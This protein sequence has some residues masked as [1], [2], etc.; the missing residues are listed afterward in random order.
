MV[1][2]AGI[3]A[4][5]FTPGGGPQ[6][7]AGARSCTAFHGSPQIQTWIKVN[8]SE[9][10]LEKCRMQWVA[11]PGHHK[12]NNLQTSP[13][14]FLFQFVPIQHSRRGG[15]CL[16]TRVAAICRRLFWRD[17]WTRFDREAASLN[18]ALPLTS[19]SSIPAGVE[20]DHK[21]ASPACLYDR[22]QCGWLAHQKVQP[23][24][25]QWCTT[26]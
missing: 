20:A 8:V 9:G 6:G 12:I 4:S 1:S 7:E 2:E 5:Y 24:Q 14:P 21:V 17:G 25:P 18:L 16:L 15:M 26:P 11:V 10:D 13:S 23:T 3:T 19:V 22:A